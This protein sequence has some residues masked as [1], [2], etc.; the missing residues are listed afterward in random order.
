MI[1]RPL[2][3]VGLALVL[4]EVLGEVKSAIA[5]GVIVGIVAILLIITI[6]GRSELIYKQWS[7]RFMLVLIA[8]MLMGYMNFTL[9]AASMG[10]S[11][12]P[13]DSV[14]A[15]VEGEIDKLEEKSN[16]IYVYLKEAQV[17]IDVADRMTETFYLLVI[18]KKDGYYTNLRP[19]DRINA[20]GTLE[21]FKMPTNPGQF[22]EF[23]FYKSLGLHYKFYSD[24]YTLTHAN[25]NFYTKGLFSL[26]E[27]LKNTYL[28]LLDEEKAG[29]IIG[30]LLGDKQFITEEISDLYKN[31]G[32]SHILAISGLHVSFL[33]TGFYN[34]LR[35]MGVHTYLSAGLGVFLVISYAIMSGFSMSTFRAVIMLLVSLGSRLAGRTY[36]AL[37]SAAAANII[38]LAIKPLLIYNSGVWL[39]FTA[40]LSLYILLP[41]LEKVMPKRLVFKML[42]P[43]LSVTIGTLPIITWC[44]FEFP[45]YSIILNYMVVLLMGILFPLAFA[46][47]IAANL[48]R[49]LGIFLAGGLDWILAFYEIAC[50][51]FMDLPGAR[52]IVGKPSLLQ[53][54]IYF[55]FIFAGLIL[56]HKFKSRFLIISIVGLLAL[57]YKN[58]ASKLGVTFLDVGQG[59]GI[60]LQIPGD[61]NILVDGGSSN[62]KGVG[63]Y[64]LIPFLKSFG[65]SKLNYIVVTHMDEDHISGII[66][67]LNEPEGLHIDNLILPDTKLV[68]EAYLELEGLAK[69]KKIAVHY[70]KQ[71]DKMSVGDV[72]LKCLH[73]A[74]GFSPDSKN[75]YSLVLDIAYHNF[76]LLLM[77]DLELNGE[78]VL[79]DSGFLRQYD[80][81]K[82]A[83]H[84][85]KNSTNEDFLNRVRPTLS[86]ISCGQDNRYGHPHEELL[87]RLVGVNSQ[88]LTTAAKG[89][90]SVTT[91]GDQIRVLEFKK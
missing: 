35:K 8:T 11:S 24:T 37:T 29:V 55:I 76:D 91:D 6:L 78:Q 54:L 12:A 41:L 79:I 27:H 66:E 49:G 32:I 14:K 13:L 9:A 45:L 26:K 68:D 34:C 46:A 63:E 72:V 87:E 39:S 65:V 2:M 3:W 15:V 28:D 48:L 25:D 16:S 86:V 61:F 74:K 73:P 44:Y 75:A 31:S 30:M 36:D 51:F 40:V 1:R 47:G 85:S 77:G 50:G 90:I 84:G 17:D 83:H 67:I 58:P 60:F 62:V 10:L 70:M 21:E 23:Y 38:M 57:C 71:G 18:V 7:A 4:G 59:D 81:L 43:G 5:L 64:R 82:V 42:N 33:G 22:N 52:Q 80:I 56:S 19:G 69:S 89:A 88:I 53:I 20:K